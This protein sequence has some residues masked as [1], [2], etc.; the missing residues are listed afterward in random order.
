MLGEGKVE[1]LI[2]DPT[3]REKRMLDVVAHVTIKECCGATVKK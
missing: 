2:E 1:P 3:N